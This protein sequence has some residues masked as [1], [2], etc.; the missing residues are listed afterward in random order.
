MPYWN[1]FTF[2]LQAFKLIFY[3]NE[4]THITGAKFADLDYFQ[5]HWSDLEKKGLTVIAPL[6]KPW[7]SRYCSPAKTLQA[8]PNGTSKTLAF[9]AT[10]NR[11]P[12][13]TGYEGRSSTSHVRL[14]WHLL[15]RTRDLQIQRCW[16]PS[17]KQFWY[18]KQHYYGGESHASL[19][20][21]EQKAQI[22]NWYHWPIS[23]SASRRYLTLTIFKQ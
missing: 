9:T 4:K 11:H 10:F 15:P 1:V 17:R 14:L 22:F 23:I 19:G 13:H 18:Q 3:S 5:S 20:K 7:R 12:Q 6:S 8:V 16:I 2:V 21:I